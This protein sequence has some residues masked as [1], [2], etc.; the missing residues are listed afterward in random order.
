M[1]AEG[2]RMKKSTPFI[3]SPSSAGY[4]IPA[5]PRFPSGGAF[6]WQGAIE[7]GQWLVVSG[8]WSVVS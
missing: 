4:I 7:S 8:Q 5:A 3:I 2:E 6:I 1:M